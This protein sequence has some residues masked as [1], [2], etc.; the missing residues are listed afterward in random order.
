M[1]KMYLIIR[2]IIPYLD[3]QYNKDSNSCP[4]CIGIRRI[5]YDHSSVIISTGFIFLTRRPMTAEVII[6]T[7]TMLTT[8]SAFQ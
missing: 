8:V 2:K 5:L 6:A 3:G 4:C 7:I 1:R